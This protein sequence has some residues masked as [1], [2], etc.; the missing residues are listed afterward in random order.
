MSYA[1]LMTYID[2]EGDPK[3]R[4]SLAVGLS[5][6]LKATLIG[7][8]ALAIRPLFLDETFSSDKVTGAD[9]EHMK[10]RVARKGDWFHRLARTEHGK[11]E[12]R[13]IFDFPVDA[14]V[15]EARSADL[16]VIGRTKTLGDA[17]TSLDPGA[18]L[19]RIGRP[20]LV[21]PDG[22]SSLRADH[23]VIGWKDTREARRAVR[24][25]LP[26][27]RNAKHVTIVEICEA[28]EEDTAAGHINDVDDYLTRHGINGDS[29]V[30]QDRDMSAA[31]QLT[32]LAQAE[33]ADLLV[34]G[35]YGHSRL[36]EWFFGG[37][38]HDLL[39]TSPICCLSLS[40]PKAERKK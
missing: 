15:R 28:G 36:G 17:Y 24:D 21:V 11:V 30:I 14:L 6:K 7:L 29:H 26:F 19:L 20:T 2:V 13:P 4:L 1:T 25:A 8:C 34:V 37:V 39:A 40:R 33:G 9:I 27:L 10:L 16:V 18:A 31:V 22:V 23:V 38:T 35:A 3:D 32:N 12:W 5:N